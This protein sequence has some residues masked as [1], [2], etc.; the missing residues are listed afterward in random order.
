MFSI[1]AKGGFFKNGPENSRKKHGAP[2]GRR[3]HS[4]KRN[5]DI[6]QAV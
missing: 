1:P 4:V 6:Q 5:W 2:F 3:A